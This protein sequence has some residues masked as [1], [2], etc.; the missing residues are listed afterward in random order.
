MS[1]HQAAAVG[2]QSAAGE[3]ERSRPG[4]PAE[5]VQRIGSLCRLAPGTRVLD[6]A[7]GTGKMTRLLRDASEAELIGCDPIDGMLRQ[8]V[9]VL[10][11]APVV[12]GVAEHIPFAA[13]SFDACIVAQAFH[14]FDGPAALAEI[15]RVLR[16]G[17]PLIAIWNTRDESV[18][19]VAAMNEIFNQ[20]EG[21]VMR[22]WQGAWRPAF[23]TPLF[24]PLGQEDF[25]Y[26]QTLTRRGVVERVLSVSFIASLPE[27]ERQ[28]VASR[29][30]GILD[31]DPQ[32]KGRD[33]VVLPYNTQLYSWRRNP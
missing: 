24:T 15:H 25:S 20:Y 1:I 12:A 14:W 8:F 6:L 19:W 31:T 10:P 4:Y 16:P 30:L 3:Y 5:A 18:A 13:Q 22:F 33:T 9:S 27:A 28:S 11:D 21:D 7:C 29:M 26:A 32:T 23:D 2:F 17:A